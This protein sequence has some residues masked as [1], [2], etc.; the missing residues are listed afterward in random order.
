MPP[1]KVLPPEGTIILVKNSWLTFEY[2]CVLPEK[3]CCVDK[4]LY[5]PNAG[6]V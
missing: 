4:Y 5:D 2:I 6:E 3:T 1:G